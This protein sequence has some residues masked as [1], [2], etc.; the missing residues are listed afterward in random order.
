MLRIRSVGWLWTML[1]EFAVTVCSLTD[2]QALNEPRVST[3]HRSG[4]TKFHMVQTDTEKAHNAKLE[5]TIGF[6]TVG[7]L[8]AVLLS[9]PNCTVSWRRKVLVV[10]PSVCFIALE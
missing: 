4:L 10:C 1:C 8:Y 6:K 2:S 5:V 9:I 7:G 3:E